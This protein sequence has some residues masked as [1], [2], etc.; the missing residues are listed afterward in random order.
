MFRCMFNSSHSF[1]HLQLYSF[2]K[3]NYVCHKSQ[4]ST[5][6]CQ[7]KTNIPTMLPLPW[8]AL[9]SLCVCVCVCMRVCVCVWGGGLFCLPL[10]IAVSCPF[11]SQLK[12][13]A[14]PLRP[15]PSVCVCAVFRSLGIIGFLLSLCSSPIHSIEHICLRIKSRKEVL[16]ELICIR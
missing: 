4:P 2:F 13:G 11:L 15:W 9:L 1:R 12:K 3:R 7:S 10:S 5:G 8:P 16:R 6:E 14:T